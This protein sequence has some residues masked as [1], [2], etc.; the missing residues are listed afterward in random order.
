MFW[1]SKQVSS[2]HLE[3][4]LNRE[5]IYFKLLKNC[6]QNI[7]LLKFFS[8]NLFAQDC[9]IYDLMDDEDILQECKSQ[10]KKLLEL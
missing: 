7:I 8:F 10:N 9:T 1:Q 2:P 3:A 6:R 4:L 5:V